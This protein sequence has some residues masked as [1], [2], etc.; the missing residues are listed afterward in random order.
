MASL[1]STAASLVPPS[2]DDAA[3]LEI[4]YSPTAEEYD[5]LKA[6]IKADKDKEFDVPIGKLLRFLRARDMDY[7]RTVA[8]L[9]SHMNWYNKFTPNLLVEDD[10]DQA[11]LK[12]GCWRVLGRTEDGSPILEVI[13]AK[14]NPHEY[15]KEDYIRYI[16]YFEAMIERMMSKNSKMIVIFD[17]E[18]W[19]LWHA[20]YISYINQLVDIAQNQYPE[21]LRRV[22]ML[23]APFIFKGVW[24]V[25]SPWLDVKT[26][27]KV[28]FLTGKEAILPELKLLT[29]SL[30]LIPARYGGDV[31]NENELPCPGFVEHM[32][33]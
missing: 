11:A 17:M 30:K 20:G 31:E 6:F 5:S 16:A 21:R 14:W 13:L 15:E 4:A 22:L 3:N 29:A 26:A 24:N 2:I 12:S 25:I 23:N 27:Q 33:E 9:H 19:A 8:M 32:N 7:D 10:V 28:V 18:G 1:L